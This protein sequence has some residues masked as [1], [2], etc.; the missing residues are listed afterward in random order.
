MVQNL[1]L[2]GKS[3]PHLK[4]LQLV[5]K[6]EKLESSNSNNLYSHHKNQRDPLKQVSETI[7]F[8][9]SFEETGVLLQFSISIVCFFVPSPENIKG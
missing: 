1:V 5:D 3:S 9:K 8:E 4:D 6:R 7:R 2:F